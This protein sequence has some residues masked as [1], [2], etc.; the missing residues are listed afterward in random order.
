M[1]VFLSKEMLL[2]GKTTSS[3]YCS[4][5]TNLSLYVD[6]TVSI[7][8]LFSLI[9]STTALTNTIFDVHQGSFVYEDFV[10]LTSKPDH[11]RSSA[12]AENQHL[13]NIFAVIYN[14]IYI[15]IIM[16]T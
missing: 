2:D 7:D 3:Y 12:F 6:L 16:H 13:D 10:T 15:V 8:C 1:L 5:L 14:Y 4:E 11:D 9:D